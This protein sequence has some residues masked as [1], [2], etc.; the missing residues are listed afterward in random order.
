[1]SLTPA[2]ATPR[3][4]AMLTLAHEIYSNENNETTMT[5][6]ILAEILQDDDGDID[7]Q[8]LSIALAMLGHVMLDMIPSTIYSGV[9]D[10]VNEALVRRFGTA[11]DAPKFEIKVTQRVTGSALLQ[12][13]ALNLQSITLVSDDD[14]SDPEDSCS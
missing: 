4:M 9:E 14:D 11:E 5:D 12:L 13:L 7:W 6:E 10:A 3:A 2:E 8:A 1:M